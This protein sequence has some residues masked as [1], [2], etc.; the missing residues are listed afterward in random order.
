[1]LLI[2]EI[3]K[4]KKNTWYY[5]YVEPKI[6]HKWTYLLN[7]NSFRHKK[8]TYSY[9]SGKDMGEG[10]NHEFGIGRYK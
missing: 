8:E 7:R 9:Q 2:N 1:M 5:L 10:T 3:R 4:R 6:R